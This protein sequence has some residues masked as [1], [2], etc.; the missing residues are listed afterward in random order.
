MKLILA[1]SGLANEEIITA[2]EEMV[3]KPRQNINVAVINEAIKGES[4]DM[5]WFTDEL[6]RLSRIIGGKIEFVD[7]QAHDI[8]YVKDRI[9]TADMIFV[10][11]VIRIIWQMFS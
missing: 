11:A 8:K 3:G 9:A 4:G 6:E 5:R 7:L 2:L 1:S 10:L